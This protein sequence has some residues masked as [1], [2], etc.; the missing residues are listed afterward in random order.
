MTPSPKPSANVT[1]A[2][3]WLDFFLTTILWSDLK[4]APN[5]VDVAF[6]NSLTLQS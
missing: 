5:E 6:A 4:N 1:C 2:R 3:A